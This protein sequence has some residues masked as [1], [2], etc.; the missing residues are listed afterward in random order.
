MKVNE[1]TTKKYNSIDLFKFLMACCVIAIHTQP[2]FGCSNSIIVEVFEAIVNCAVPFFFMASG[3]LLAVKMKW[4]YSLKENEVILKKY[5]VRTLKMY[6]FWSFI[7]FPVEIYHCLHMKLSLLYC[8]RKYICDFIFLGAHYNVW[9]LWYLLSTVYTIL[10]IIL[11]NR[12]KFSIGM[13]T[14]IGLV[15]LFFSF[16]IDYIALAENEELIPA[17]VMIRSMIKNTIVSGRILRGLFYIPCGMLIARKRLPLVM[18]AFIFSFFF[19][20][21]CVVQGSLTNELCTLVCSITLFQLVLSIDL[22]DANIYPMLRKMST[23]MYFIHMYIWIAYYSLVY[24]K[25]TYG[26]DCFVVTLLISVFVAYIQNYISL[27]RKN[28]TIMNC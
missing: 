25:Q 6:I 26:G 21:R 10:F 4:P 17:F 19:I 8:I 15:I 5:L 13:I 1:E 3:Y 16:A 7:Y 14:C 22:K 18:N 2:V 28:K 24:H 23:S 12:R 27:N 20:M 11:S 9:M